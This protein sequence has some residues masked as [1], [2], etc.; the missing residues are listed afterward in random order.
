MK[1]TIKALL[2]ASCAVLTLAICALPLLAQDQADDL[3]AD[4]DDVVME[5]EITDPLAPLDP[6]EAAIMDEL[7]AEDAAAALEAPVE[8]VVIAEPVAISP[9]AAETIVLEDPPS[10]EEQTQDGLISL[11]LDEVPLNDVVRMFTKISGANIIAAGT[12]LAGSVTVS[13]YDVEWKDAFLSI[14]DSQ[15]MTLVERRP[16]IYTIISKT[17]AEAEPVIVQT[18]FLKYVSPSA[19]KPVIEKMLISSNASVSA[20]NA[21]GIVVQETA[22]RLTGIMDTI[23]RIDQPR[24]QVLIEAKFVELNDKA[25]KNLGIDWSMLQGF[26][27]GGEFS[28]SY[29]EARR[30]NEIN[31]DAYISRALSSETASESVQNSSGSTDGAGTIGSSLNH[32]SGSSYVGTEDAGKFVGRNV[33][34]YDDGK[35]AAIPAI[36]VAKA[37]SAVLNPVQFNVV[38]SALKE[39]DDVSIISNPKIIVANGET[40]EIHVGERR[41]YFKAEPQGDTGDRYAYTPEWLDIGIVVQVTPVVNTSSNIT[42]AIEPTLSRYIGEVSAGGDLNITAPITSKRTVKTEFIIPSGRTIAIGG[43]TETQDREVVKKI[44]LL[45]DIP[46]IGKYL[47]SHTSKTKMQDEVVI[48][49]TVI[50]ADSDSLTELDGL[51]SGGRLIHR[52]MAGQREDPNAPV[53]W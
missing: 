40:A 39:N 9:A 35:M 31:S 22:I 6:A 16:E 25:I 21:N 19:V 32:A 1:I 52:Y 27:V 43:L 34:S 13:L 17:A 38:L 46:I 33:E 44:P 37:F 48:F 26:K 8:D 29:T 4:L 11:N 5:D 45:G 14:L 12:N 42:V 53:V 18:V 7:A 36:D 28:G 3:L 20:V 24:P 10:T 47:F 49:V 15:D 41:P 50:T 30:L 2:I 51:P 23:H